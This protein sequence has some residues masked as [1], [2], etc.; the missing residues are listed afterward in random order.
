MQVGAT[1]GGIEG[2]IATVLGRYLEA[3]EVEVSV[4]IGG[5]GLHGAQ[6]VDPGEQLQVVYAMREVG[7][8]G[9]G[10]ESVAQV[11][12]RGLFL[13]YAVSH[14]DHDGGHVIIGLA[15]LGH[16]YLGLLVA[17]GMGEGHV[18]LRVAQLLLG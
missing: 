5:H 16:L 2:D 3:A 1:G 18:G 14:A 4:R 10:V 11:A 6:V 7:P 12:E 13:A 9:H 17:Y 8:G 15:Y